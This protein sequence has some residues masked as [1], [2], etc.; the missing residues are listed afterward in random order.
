MVLSLVV[1]SD[2]WGLVR[3]RRCHKMHLVTLVVTVIIQIFRVV[4]YCLS[5][6]YLAAVAGLIFFS[7]L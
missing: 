4:P 3:I 7:S 1:L 6:R 2:L 5:E